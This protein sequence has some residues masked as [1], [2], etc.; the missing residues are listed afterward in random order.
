M[1]D[2]KKV[3]LLTGAGGLLGTEFCRRYASKYAI[4]AVCGRRAV[5]G[6]PDQYVRAIDPLSAGADAPENAHPV[7]TVHA[8]LAVAGQLERAVELAMARFSRI[9]LLVNAAAH[10]VWG[11]MLEETHVVD[12]IERQFLVNAIVPFRL[13]V[14]VARAFWRDRAAENRRHNR[15]VINISS[16]AG[17]HIYPGSGQSVYS[18]SKAALNYLTC[19]IAGE[20]QRIG[21][22]AVGLAP[23]SFPSLLSTES[24]ADAI[25]RL[26][27]SDINGR[28]LVMDRDREYLTP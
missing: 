13:A 8:D 4:V 5:A 20:F 28:V 27:E 26:A 18:A 12:S 21:V 24:V 1:D 19:H 16:T 2:T 15:S 25:D 23:T 11:S 6:V 17:V 9:D 10:S 7:F 22:R 14:L 3:C